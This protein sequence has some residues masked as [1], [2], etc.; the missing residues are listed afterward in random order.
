MQRSFSGGSDPMP[1]PASRDLV[2]QSGRMLLLDR[3]VA[4]DGE[5][6]AAEVTIRADAL[7]AQAQGVGAWVGIEYM[8]QAIAALGGIAALRR[9][10]K[11]QIGFLVGTRHYACNVPYFPLGATLQVVVR[12]AER[13][14][15]RIESFVCSITGE[16]I[17]ADA[18][19]TVFR[20]DNA[21]LFIT[22]ANA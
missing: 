12:S 2:P 8:A 16:G 7:F 19:I 1:L 20:P 14:D 6:L 21:R 4:A 11:P 22:E 5:S 17:M 13:S 9:Q 10:E 15:D 18:A 3:V